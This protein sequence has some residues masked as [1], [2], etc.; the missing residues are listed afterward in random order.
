MKFTHLKK[1]PGYNNFPVATMMKPS[2]PSKE[3]DDGDDDKY[4]V[5]K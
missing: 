1:K 2:P 4:P 5:K 3:E